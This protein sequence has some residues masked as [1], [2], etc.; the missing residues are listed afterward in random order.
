MIRGVISDFGG[1]LTT[2]LA[3]SFAVFADRSGMSMAELGSA[4]AAIIAREG[5]HP[6]YELECGRM[7]EAQF[8][9]GLERA[10][11]D[12]VG[13]E[14]P[15]SGFA[16]ALWAGLAP[17]PPM[18][19]LMA[20]LRGEGFRMALLTNNVRE[21]EPRW[22]AMA[23]ID[24]IFELVVDSAYVGMRKPDPEIYEL[25]LQGL[26]LAAQECLFVDDL[27]RNCEAA[28]DVGMQAVVYRDAEQAAAEIRA[29]LGVTGQPVS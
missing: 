3:G 17:N 11:R 12:E 14:V 7:S 13:R 27:E 8:L 29:A 10:L 25:T 22:R 15:C 16:E 5:A 9:A 19:D 24:D 20:E 4:L 6:L 28:V 21:W 2:P 26:G 1:V 18:I 23:P